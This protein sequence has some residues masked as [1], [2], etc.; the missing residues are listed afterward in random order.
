MRGTGVA[1]WSTAAGSALGRA[2][3]GSADAER[4]GSETCRAGPDIGRPHRIRCGHDDG[5]APT[6]D[7]PRRLDASRRCGHAR[8]LHPARRRH[9]P[10]RQLPGRAAR[11]PCPRPWHDVV[12]RQWGERLIRSW[13]EADWWGAP[14]RVGDRIGRL[15][16]AGAR[17]GRRHRLDL[18]QPLQG[19]RRRRRGCAPGAAWCSP[20]PAPSPPTSTS[21]TRPPGCRPRGRRRAP[22]A[23]RVAAVAEVGDDLALAASCSASTTA[24]ASSGTSR[25]ITRAAHDVGALAC[26]DLCHS[27]GVLAVDLDAHGAD[28]AVGCGYKYLNGGPGAPAFLYVAARHQDDFDQPL[29]GWHGHAHAVRDEPALRAGRR[30]SPAPGSARRRCCRLLALEAALTA[31][32][33]LSVAR[34]AG[35][36]RS[37]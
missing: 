7:R 10:R 16:G 27:A 29:T 6:P 9:L 13:N 32:D 22:R 17:S 12:R 18:G 25:A 5:A 24:P 30:A 4:L 2:C 21:P 26:W 28:L 36:S 20:T 3:H 35:R 33:G 23:R 31:Y 37:R 34:R 14:T 19:G 8:P 15:V 1:C 11:R